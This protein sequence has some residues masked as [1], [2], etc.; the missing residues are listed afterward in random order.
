MI[1]L[2]EAGAEQAALTWLRDLGWQM[3]RGRTSPPLSRWG[4]N[5]YG[6]VV[7]ERRL[8][9]ALTGLNPNLVAVALG[10]E[11]L[12]TIAQELVQTVRNNVTIDLTL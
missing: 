10:D 1:T 2:I 4:W 8:R 5:G 6:Q 7:S 3:G 11:T 12:R 9:D